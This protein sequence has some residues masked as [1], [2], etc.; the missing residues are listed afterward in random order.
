[1]RKGQPQPPSPHI[2]LFIQLNSEGGRNTKK[3]PNPLPSVETSCLKWSNLH[4]NTPRLSHMRAWPRTQ[5]N[6]RCSPGI[7]TYCM[8]LGQAT[9]PLSTSLLTSNKGVI[10]LPHSQGLRIQKG[11]SHKCG[12]FSQLETFQESM[13][14]KD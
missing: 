4:L 12:L 7:T 13:Q 10:I 9:W 11:T 1:M 6:L 5:T 2:P 3:S 14:L 8:I